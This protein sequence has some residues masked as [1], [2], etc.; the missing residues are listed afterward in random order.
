MS[1]KEIYEILFS[2]TGTVRRLVSLPFWVA[3]IE[4]AFLSLLP[5]PPLT[6]DQVE[7][8]KHDNVVGQKAKTLSTLGIH[9]TSMASV[10][11]TYLERYRSGGRFAERRVHNV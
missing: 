5:T 1:F 10:L 9:P 11:P 3:K 4:A 6:P 8:L 7:S 2:H